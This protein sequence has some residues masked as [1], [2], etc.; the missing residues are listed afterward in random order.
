MRLVGYLNR[1]IFNCITCHEGIGGVYLTLPLISVLDGGGWSTP[2]PGHSTP[3]EGASVG[4][5][6][7]WGWLGIGAGMD[8]CRKYHPHLG[9]EP[10]DVQL[11]RA[12]VTHVALFYPSKTNAEPRCCE[13]SN[14]PVS[15]HIMY[16]PASWSSGQNFWLLIT[17][18]R[19]RFPA[20]PWGFSLWGEGGSPWWPW[21]G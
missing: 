11:P 14:T 1:N 5:H 13:H 21:S 18:S 2:H 20:L 16:W 7:S 15:A 19:V 6:C 8:G 4:I 17:R 9:Y 12:S 10:W 3:R